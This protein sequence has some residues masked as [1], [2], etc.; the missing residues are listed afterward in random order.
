[1]RMPATWAWSVR[2]DAGEVLAELRFRAR[3]DWAYGL[4]AGYVGSAEFTGTVR[5]RRVD[6]G[7]YVEWVEL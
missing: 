7:A 2:D 6:G 1:M 3:D 4:G 5:G